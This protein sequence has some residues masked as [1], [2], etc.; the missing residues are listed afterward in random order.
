MPSCGARPP[1]SSLR[2]IQAGL[3]ASADE[4]ALVQ[5]SYLIAEVVMIPLSGMLSRVLSTRILFAIS[6]GGFTIASML[7]ATAGSIGGMVVWRVLQ[8]LLG[9]AMI[10]PVFATSFILFP[11]ERRA[12]ISVLIRLVATTAPT[13][14]LAVIDQ[15]MPHH[16]RHL[17]DQ[18]TWPRQLVT[19]TLDALTGR[20]ADLMVAA[21]DKAAMQTLMGIVRREASVLTYADAFLLMSLVQ[22]PK[23]AKPPSDAH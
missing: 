15:H 22:K 16:M 11:P 13:I 23:S 21:P 19:S 8:G 4:I 10:P 2:E 18:L 9:G 7:C 20:F 14:S 12:G 1:S 5:T 3:G 17:L 6:C